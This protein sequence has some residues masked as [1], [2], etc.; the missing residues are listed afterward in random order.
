MERYTVLFLMQGKPEIYV[1]S[2]ELQKTP[3]ICRFLAHL[4][5][6]ST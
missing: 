5:S 1:L 6:K 4:H 3:T 2:L